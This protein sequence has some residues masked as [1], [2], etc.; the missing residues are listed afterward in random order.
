[1]VSPL[2]K[3]W[4]ETWLRAGPELEAIRRAELR[5]VDTREAVRQL[6]G[7]RPPAEPG[8]PWSGLVDQQRWFAKVARRN[9]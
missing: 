6:F 9:R 1:M 4:V 2:V 7:N 5:S 8:P 3:R